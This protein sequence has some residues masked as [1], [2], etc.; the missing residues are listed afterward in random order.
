MKKAV[1]LDRETLG[2]DAVLT[3]IE[4]LV[5]LAVYGGTTVE[6]TAERIKDAEIVITNKVWL[7]RE[8]MEAAP[9]LALICISATGTNN[10]DHDAAAKL[11]IQVMNVSDYSTN[12]VAQV[13]LSMYFHI[14]SQLAIYDQFV[15]SGGW[16]ELDQFT[17]HVA[18]F[19]ELGSK[20]WGIIGLGRIGLRVAE[21]VSAFGAEVVYHSTS[22]KNINS[23]YPQLSLNE[24][25]SSCDVVSIHAPLNEQT[26]NLIGKE[27]IALLKD[28]SL[29]LNLGRGGIVDE[30]A[31]ADALNQ[32]EI[33]HGT[34]V[35][36]TEPMKKGHPYLTLKNPQQ[37]VISPHIGWAS[38]EARQILMRKIAQNIENFLKC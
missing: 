22:G 20:R 3:E 8:E 18:P 23:D 15:K 37:L 21:Q 26:R 24:L 38:I 32:R 34:D 36:A 35:L 12:S 29:L 5:D 17:S 28:K 33:Y 2:D 31:M 6:Q 25:L 9:K 4:S 19:N 1:L 7:G 10:V 14:Y 27:Q 16:C 11:G 13:T 30:D